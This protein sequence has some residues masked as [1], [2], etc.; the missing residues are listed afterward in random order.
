MLVERSRRP[1]W[2][3]ALLIAAAMLPCPLS[4]Q[5]GELR[6]DGI[7]AEDGL[8]QD[9]VYCLLQDARGFIWIGTENGLTRYDGRRFTVFRL[10]VGN[11]G[12]LPSDF[13][14]TLYETADGAIWVGTVAGLARLDPYTERFTRYTHDPDDPTTLSSGDITDL[15]SDEHGTLWVATWQ[16]LNRYVPEKDCFQRVDAAEGL[17]DP[18]LRKL[19]LDGEGRFLVGSTAGLSEFDRETGSFTHLRLS[20]GEDDPMVTD[21]VEGVGGLLWLATE[22]GLFQYAPG[23]GTHRVF[24]RSDDE[25]SGPPHDH[26]RA[27]AR[28]KSGN[29]WLATEQGLAYFDPGEN[30]FWAHH[31]DPR[32][33]ESLGNDFCAALMF[34]RGGL[35]WIGTRGA[36][37]DIWNPRT[38][39]IDVF[40]HDPEDPTSLGNEMVWNFAEDDTGDIWMAT[41]GG[42]EHLIRD[43]G[44]IRHH[45]HREGDPESLSTDA[46]FS[47][48][49]DEEN[50]V[51]AGSQNGLNRLD[52]TT[53]KVRRYFHDG[54]DTT[55]IS[56]N[57]IFFLMMDGLGYL[58]IGTDSGLDRWREDSDD[59]K[60]YAAVPED[61][62]GLSN[63]SIRCLH[64]GS[65]GRIWVGTGN[66]VNRYNPEIDGFD[67]FLVGEEHSTSS[68][69]G[70]V[71]AL[72]E[73]EPGILW[74]GYSGSGLARLDFRANRNHPDIE[75]LPRDLFPN[76][77]LFSLLPDDRHRLW[78]S[79]NE[80]LIRFEPDT[81][82]LR[83]F[84]RR[85]GLLT[86][87]LN[88]G[89]ALEARDGKLFFGTVKG[90]N[91]FYPE[92][93]DRTFPAPPVEVTRVVLADGLELPP[94]NP[95]RPL[96]LGWEQRRSFSIRFAALDY[97]KQ[98]HNR[99][100]YRLQGFDREDRLS[101]TAEATYTNLS[102]GR[103]TFEVTA[104]NSDG[105]ES[106]EPAVLR[107]ILEPPAWRSRP[108]MVL[109]LL[110][111]AGLV[112]FLVHTQR[113]KQVE[114]ASAEREIRD[115][116]K[117]L[118][119]ALWGSGGHMWDWNDD[120][121]EL[122]RGDFAEMLGYLPDEIPT[123]TS[124]Q[125]ALIHP[126]DLF[127]VEKAWTDHITHKTTYYE[128]EYRIR[129]KD[130][131]WRWIHERGMAASRDRTGRARRMSGIFRDIS[132]Q[133][134][135][136]DKI[137]LFAKAFENTSEAMMILNTRQVIK[138]VN[139][140]FTHITGYSQLEITGQ[141]I[142]L[143]SSN[144]N[145]ADFYERL[146][147][148]VHTTDRWEGEIWARRKSG[149]EF[150][151]WVNMSLLRD[152]TG[153]ITNYV[154]VFSDIT[155][156]KRAEE[157]LRHLANYDTLTGLPNRTLFGDRL[158]Q[159][160]RHANRHDQMLA[161]L[162][163]DLDHFKKINDSFGHGVGDM[164]L[165]A[166]S[167]RLVDTLRDEDTVA[168]L[169]GDELIV[170]L[171]N[172]ESPQ[173]A[174]H[175]ATKLLAGMEEAFVLEGHEVRI[176]LSIGISLFPE[177]G[178]D[179][180]AL[181]KNADTAMYHA[182]SEGR[183]NFQF[184]TETMNVRAF[185]LLKLENALRKAI[186]LDQ[187]VLRYQ[188]QF[189]IRSGTMVG[190]EALVRWEHPE[191][192]LLSP[193]TF[194]PLAEETGVI[195]ALG[196]WVL[197]TAC[198]Q[199][200]TWREAGLTELRMAVN[201]SA[202]QMKQRDISD[203]VAEALRIHRLPAGVLELE[204]TEGILI[205]DRTRTIAMLEGFRAL[206]IKLAMDDFGTGYSSLGYLRDFPIDKLKI[207]RTF[208][209]E[210]I[211]S[212]QSAA[213]AR[214]IINLAENLELEVM[215]EGV[216]TP[217]QLQFLSRN[218]C[219][220]IQGY[221]LSEPEPAS[222]IP[223]LS[224]G[225]H[226][227]ELIASLEV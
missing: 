95:D 51:W 79:T 83:I 91:A 117:R 119:L 11:P 17:P 219:H 172:L 69:I 137:R 106:L 31:H 85:D 88:E 58:W 124:A 213:V 123:E 46:L 67:A 125:R 99:F 98:G 183:N 71:T 222:V 21:I 112:M 153:L 197:E 84:D 148:M 168:R 144:R 220:T 142:S 226:L 126:S 111:G 167:K 15:L 60:R 75:R 136:E 215:A 141:H 178:L 9:W 138:A 42:L 19:F 193:D 202:E 227:R 41:D 107:L 159:A 45:R 14:N 63:P 208:V 182:K 162:F 109:Y 77:N 61:P 161:L 160:L 209:S 7:R 180:R 166:V 56:N 169:G 196:A 12:S 49:V 133:K 96:I 24:R 156:R 25:T 4:A 105:I 29:L 163:L 164:L 110:A 35:L 154:A 59:F 103:Y 189:D 66:G 152:S 40:H 38:G 28:E 30:R 34:D 194:I 6:L 50:R 73:E 221:L 225:T 187:L 175:V 223:G 92:D 151:M 179:D 211:T 191:K 33:P 198:R 70:A 145:E 57:V 122:F 16:G 100:R 44:E 10:E 203:L 102:A 127:G 128:A 205:R 130:G 13:I 129:A 78:I 18:H 217:E 52:P 76:L 150:P 214:T 54:E 199:L 101:R 113:R 37:V 20:E 224:K 3:P 132:E 68:G 1:R 186:E 218:G 81:M 121:D 143:L 195:H 27:L 97:A 206:G 120:T 2:W 89:A 80:G 135:T 62:R 177:D 200:A 64:Q 116:E 216:E 39:L 201:L 174:A 94:R 165:Q 118:K 207:D 104:I 72:C 36:G 181:L 115:S 204:I 171:E 149:H 155:E 210:V 108:A 170:L 74:V 192:G 47:V 184:Y 53:G 86:N 157:E 32:R 82:G 131:S 48:A 139:A 43:T 158:I 147:G 23:K 22:Q 65:S 176:S 114:R 185:E 93:L 8:S 173:Q 212:S 146:A 87:E 134:R 26:I 140:A 90:V 188:P 190:V 5:R 55:S